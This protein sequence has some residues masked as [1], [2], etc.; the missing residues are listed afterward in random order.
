MT[1]AADVREPVLHVDL[2]AF[3]AS[4]E[5]RKDPSLAGRPVLVG[6]AGARGVVMSASYEARRF[7]VGSAMPASRARRL[8]PDAI[9]IPPDFAAYRETSKR[10]WELVGERLDRSRRRREAPLFEAPGDLPRELARLGFL[11]GLENRVDESR[12]LTVEEELDA[13][14]V[15]L[16]RV[17]VRVGEEPDANGRRPPVGKRRSLLDRRSSQRHWPQHLTTA[18]SPNVSARGTE[19]VDRTR[20]APRRT[21]GRGARRCEAP[22]P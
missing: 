15:D 8:C 7:G 11:L 5:V 10:V 22:H 9:V 17:D 1:S 18:S 14:G 4:V 3:Y 13:D 6:G 19:E 21:H 12:V 2:D 20:A 16:A